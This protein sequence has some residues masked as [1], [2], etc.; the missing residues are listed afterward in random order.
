MKV[1][2]DE[3]AFMPVRCHPTDSGLDLR[4]PIDCVVPANGS[5]TIDTGVSV[6]L[7]KNTGGILV[8]KSGLMV[9]HGI[10]STGLI[11]ET[12][13]S[14]IS[15]KLFNHTDKDYEV[16]VGDK[17]SQLVIIPVLYEKVELVD[18]IEEKGRGGG[19]FGSTGR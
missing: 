6:E 9:K 2:L 16:L 3:G 11:D 13:S 17:I 10:T 18:N 4:S 8:S 1:K 15:V 19:K 7:P 5:I 14:S 12:Y